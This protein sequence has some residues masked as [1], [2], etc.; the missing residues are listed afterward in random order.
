M[1]DIWFFH[2]SNPSS[3]FLIHNLK[4][5]KFEMYVTRYS[6]I[7]LRLF[8]AVDHSTKPDSALWAMAP[9]LVL[10]Y[11]QECRIWFCTIAIVHGLVMHYGP[12]HMIW[13]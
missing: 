13:F 5:L 4:P 12:Q 7:F 11:G 2:E 3:S 1:F 9:A 10:S 8:P 6:T